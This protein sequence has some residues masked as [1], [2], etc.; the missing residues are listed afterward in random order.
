[1]RGTHDGDEGVD[2][3]EQCL[4]AVGLFLQV[5]DGRLELELVEE[6]GDGGELVVRGC[7]PGRVMRVI[8]VGPTGP[9]RSHGHGH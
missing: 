7:L 6:M 1:M 8:V 3:V 9:T 5:L 2:G 4:V